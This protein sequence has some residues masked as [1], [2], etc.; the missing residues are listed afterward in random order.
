MNGTVSI[1]SKEQ[2][3]IMKSI[4]FMTE[5]SNKPSREEWALMSDE[6]RE[7]VRRQEDEEYADPSKLPDAR[8]TSVKNPKNAKGH[9]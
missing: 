2:E 8:G 3:T 9:K 5:T 1:K 6:E 7:E 4:E